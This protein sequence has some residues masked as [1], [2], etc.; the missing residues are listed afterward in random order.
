[1]DERDEPEPI[2]AAER[3]ARR[4]RINQLGQRLGFVGDLEY[5][6]VYSHSGAAQCWV[7]PRAFLMMGKKKLSEIKA[8]LVALLDQLPAPTPQVW[9]RKKTEAAQT[10]RTRDV[11]S[12]EMLCAALQCETKKTRTSKMQ[13][14][15][16]KR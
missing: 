2:T 16:S 3:R 7:L 14:R 10:D 8:E 5:R 13:R 15:P 9:L 6:H 1:M 4:R 12:L 11:E